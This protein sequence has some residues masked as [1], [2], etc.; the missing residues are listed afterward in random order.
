LIE[1]QLGEYQIEAELGTG[2]MGSVYVASDGGGRRYALKV[3]HSHLIRTEG[4]LARFQ[5][6]ARI[7]RRVQHPNVVRTYDVG[8]AVVEGETAH[9]LVM[10]CVEGQTLRDLLGELGRV[11]E[12]LCRH[13]GNEVAKGLAAIH[14]AGV[15]HRDLKPENVLITEDHVV[16]VM[17]LGVARLTDEVIR[18]S[19]TGTFAGS[20]LYAAPEQFGGDRDIDGRAD[21]YAVGLLLYE[22][23]TGKHPFSHDDI[24]VTMQAQRHEPAR[25]VAELNPQLSPFFEFLVGTLL[26]K[27]RDDRFS[28][29][30][31]LAAV[32]EQGERSAW[33]RAQALALRTATR[34]PLRRIRIPR[35]TALYGRDELL[36]RLKGHYEQAKQ[37]AGQVVILDGGAGIGKTRLVDEFVGRLLHQGEDHNFLFG[38]YPPGGAA[39]AAGAFS[40][41]YREHFGSEGLPD[42][43]RRYLPDTPILIPAFAALLRGEPLAS[44]EEPLTKDSLH[45]VFVHATR[46][47]AEERTTVVVIEDLHF[48]P[49]EGMAL[50]SALA[51]AVPGH[52]ILLVGTARPGLPERWSTGIERLDHAT[53]LELSRLSPK[54]LERLLVDAFRSPRLAEELGW[55]IATKSDGNPFFIF[56]IIRGLREGQ[57]L[58]EQPDGS[59]DKTAIIQDIR[60]P[61]SVMDLIQARISNVSDEDKDLLDLASCCGFEFDPGLVA[62][63]VGMA[64]IPALKRF[65]RI[66]ARHRLVRSAGDHF[67]FDHNQ[68]RE[69][70]YEG[71]PEPLARAYHCALGEAMERRLS[72]S[73]QDPG[74]VVGSKAVDLCEHFLKGGQGE[75]AL[76]YLDAALDHL[77]KG[78]LNAAAAELADRALGEPGLLSGS[79]RV[80]I[81][82]RKQK[83]LDL[84]GQRTEERATLD[85]AMEIATETGETALRAQVGNLLGAHLI[86][87]ADYERAEEVMS[88]AIAMARKAGD[89]QLE[90]RAVGNVGSLLASVGRHEEAREH[91]ERSVAVAREIGDKG[92]EARA[93]GN[94]GN[95][96]WTLGEY[97]KAREIYEQCEARFREIGQRQSEAR[98]TGNLGIFFQ[99]TGRYTEALD[100]FERQ[101]AISR[102][103]GHRE[104]EASALLGIG[105][106]YAQFGERERAAEFLERARRICAETGARIWETF[107]LNALASVVEDFD[108]RLRLYEEALSIARAISFPSGIANS[109]YQLGTLLAEHDRVEEAKRHLAGALETARKTGEYG[110]IVKSLCQLARL[111]ERPVEEARVALDE[112]VARLT[113]ADRIDARNALWKA[114]GDP[115]DLEEA[116][117]LLMDMHARLPE[118]YRETMAE[119]VTTFREILTAYKAQ[120]R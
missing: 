116:H 42:T 40:T 87:I 111:G 26:S 18:L 51:L 78:Y 103:I 10:E 69:A 90:Q 112:N 16:K 52:R 14:A 67:L 43:L 27:R 6:E 74:E 65:A 17:D 118:P 15:I 96:Y 49:H 99:A 58:A 53:R 80:E 29:A 60:I 108:R 62:A 7:G 106:V 63:A 110:A 73:G 109:L 86:Q 102:E 107:T 41:A 94:L 20:V 75:R 12:E 97:E 57:L 76:V 30:A 50:F 39:T 22:L 23:A 11:P 59:W 79:G 115:N 101:L 95:F 89:R 45:T 13:I 54:D 88:D 28:S 81:L 48:A 64:L 104:G 98:A 105:V 9:F 37:G 4:L 19:H 44:G 24:R 120:R 83:R 46:A 85:E 56:E 25:P 113:F 72:E 35:E 66:E 70:L 77:E 55:Q 32:L 114:A 119:R 34:R 31:E 5:R 8:E 38:S 1:K 68:V 33:W 21:L 93:T 84:L 92:G 3:L 82:L 36:E 71:M 61:S 91:H 100:C 47:L 117:R 2:G